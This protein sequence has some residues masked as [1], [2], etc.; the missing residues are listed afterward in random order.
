[1]ISMLPPPKPN[2]HAPYEY[3]SFDEDESD[4][5]CCFGYPLTGPIKFT[6]R[7]DQK[8]AIYE[9]DMTEERCLV[10]ALE[11]VCPHCH[12]QGQLEL[13]GTYTTKSMIYIPTKEFGTKLRVK[14]P[15]WHCLACN[16]IH[17]EPEHLRCYKTKFSKTVAMMYIELLKRLV[18]GNGDY[19]QPL[20]EQQKSIIES[21]MRQDHFTQEQQTVMWR[22]L[23]RELEFRRTFWTWLYQY[24]GLDHA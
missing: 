5:N 8:W 18:A 19:D 23:D 4:F 21:Q 14:E 12:A 22:I 20:T 11:R 2:V 16:V 9:I 13:H 1:M 6:K 17:K 7:G 15:I 10:P 3:S 24:T